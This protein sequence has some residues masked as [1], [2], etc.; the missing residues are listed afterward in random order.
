M[1]KEHTSGFPVSDV[2]SIAV[3]VGAV[4]AEVTFI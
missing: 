1:G 2:N 4:I 3:L